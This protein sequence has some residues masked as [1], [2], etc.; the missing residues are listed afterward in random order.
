MGNISTKKVGDFQAGVGK[1]SATINIGVSIFFA[2]I[3]VLAAIGLTIAAF[4]PI[5]PINCPG[6]QNDA[7]FSFNL[8]CN[9]SEDDDSDDDSA[10][11]KQART[12]FTNAKNHCAHKKPNRWFLL[13]LVLIPLAAL[14]VFVSFW[15]KKEVY[16]N[17]TAAQVGGTLTEFALVQDMLG[18]R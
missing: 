6:V 3:M 10:E 18:N 14:I 17:R 7:Q 12:A 2:V 13:G 1:A 8:F 5:T 11:C 9:S 16:R 4:I 15:W